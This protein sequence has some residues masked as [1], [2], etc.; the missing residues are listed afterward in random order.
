MDNSRLNLCISIVELVEPL[1]KNHFKKKNL[2]L[3]ACLFHCVSKKEIQF[4]SLMIIQ[5]FFLRLYDFLDTLNMNLD[6][7]ELKSNFEMED[8]NQSFR[9][10]VFT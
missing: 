7:F 4:D 10:Y 8:I 1:P 3:I 2:L 6:F 9:S 5:I